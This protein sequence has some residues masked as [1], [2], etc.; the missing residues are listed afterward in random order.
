MKG[1]NITCNI[2]IEEGLYL[3]GNE[4]ELERA[5][6][7]IITN[8]VNFSPNNSTITINANIK[9]RNL[10]IE[11]KD[12]GKGFSEK[13]LK[14]GKEQFFME[15]ESRTESGHH[16]LGLYI[17]NNIIKNYNGELILSNDKNGGGVVQVII[18]L[19]RG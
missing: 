15:D 16:G 10:I 7:N 12:Q 6:M 8:A 19:V 5:F 17:T 2:D 9:N 3:R 13:I 14:H 4:I 11:V 1:I 18:P